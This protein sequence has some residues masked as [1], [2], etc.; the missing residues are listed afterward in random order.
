[1]VVYATRQD[2]GGIIEFK[3]NGMRRSSTDMS[4]FMG[5]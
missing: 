4:G 2:G 5:R 3:S 1:M